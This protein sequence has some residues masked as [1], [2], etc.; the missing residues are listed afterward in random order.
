[1]EGCRDLQKFTT[2]TVVAQRCDVLSSGREARGDID[3]RQMRTQHPVVRTAQWGRGVRCNAV[4]RDR[5]IDNV[6]RLTPWWG[7]ES[8]TTLDSDQKA[9]EA[10]QEAETEVGL[11]VMVVSGAKEPC[12]PPARR[13]DRPN[14][15]IDVG[16]TA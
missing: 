10:L 1:M 6:K 2:G 13:T 9:A 8:L 3:R 7:I 12:G 16:L 4:A 14:P 11:G 5:R 15:V